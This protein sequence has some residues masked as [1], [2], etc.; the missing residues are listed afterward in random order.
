VNRG[1][2]KR[3]VCR[4]QIE[5]NLRKEQREGNSSFTKKEAEKNSPRI[6]KRKGGEKIRKA[7]TEV[8]RPSQDGG[9][10]YLSVRRGR[11]A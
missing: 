11:V 7:R 9:E 10:N 1:K 6:K 8:K 3:M 2:G 5:T 4:G